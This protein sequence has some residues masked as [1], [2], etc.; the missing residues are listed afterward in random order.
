[1]PQTLRPLTKLSY[2]FESSL[3]AVDAPSRRLLNAALLATC[4]VLLRGLARRVGAPPLVALFVAVLWALHPVHAE[5]IIA[6]AGRPVLLNLCL[7]LASAALLLSNRPWWALGCAALAVTAR[8]SGLPWLVVCS[9]LAAR[10]LGASRLKVV[11]T[12]GAA[13]VLGFGAVLSVDTLRDLVF[14]SLAAPGAVNRL[15]L[16][17]AA[18]FRGTV[19]LVFDPASFTL[20]MDFAPV[21]WTRSALILGALLL[22][23]SALW[24]AVGGKSG[25]SKNAVVQER[26]YAARVAALLWLCLVIPLHSVIPKVDPFTARPFSA[27]LAPLL[28]LATYFGVRWYERASKR[29]Q[30]ATRNT[31]ASDGF[32]TARASAAFN[33]SAV[34]LCLTVVSCLAFV[35]LGHLTHARATLYRD[36]VALWRDAA[37][38]STQKT[39]P[40]VNWGTLLAKRGE[41]RQ[42]EAVLE[43]A[44]ARDDGSL[45]LASRLGAVRRLQALEAHE[46]RR[47][48]SFD[49]TIP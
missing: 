20:D 12:A 21:G 25:A 48:P 16:Q 1:M 33:P 11:G 3:G 46:T 42:A 23:G 34:S 22:Y 30:V 6:L 10:Q 15:G 41:L 37:L 45:E 2:A 31:R 43:A 38:R 7:T 35:T 4:I 47:S 44:V 8:E 32:G 27:S 9:A 40:L 13:A 18:L 29:A 36:A 5:T 28:L 24:L 17:W 26:R 49:P 19:G 14:G 39:R